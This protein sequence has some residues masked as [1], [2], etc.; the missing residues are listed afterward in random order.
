[1]VATFALL[2]LGYWGGSQKW[3]HQ[4]FNGDLLG[5]IVE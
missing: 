1:M 5:A 4:I 2:F 3:L